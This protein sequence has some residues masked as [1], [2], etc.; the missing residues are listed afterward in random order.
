MKKSDL[1]FGMVVRYRNDDLRLYLP[2]HKSDKLTNQP[3]FCALET[4]SDSFSDVSNWN[5]DLTSKFRMSTLDIMEVFKIG[6]EGELEF[7]WKR[8][9]ETV[10]TISQIEKAL[11]IKGLKIV[12]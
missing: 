6:K 3:C 9:T 2:F 7:V 12:K 10:M 4:D 11:Q 8:P 5:D 1:K